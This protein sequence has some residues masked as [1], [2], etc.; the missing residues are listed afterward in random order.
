VD[1]INNREKLRTVIDEFARQHKSTT[2]IAIIVRTVRDDGR[3]RGV[4]GHYFPLA[5]GALSAAFWDSVEA[6]DEKRNLLDELRNL[7]S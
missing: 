7:R 4:S 1:V 5:A 3:Q 2:G 6:E